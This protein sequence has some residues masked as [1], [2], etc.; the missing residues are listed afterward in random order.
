[1]R[2]FKPVFIATITDQAIENVRPDQDVLDLFQVLPIQLQAG[3]T[4]IVLAMVAQTQPVDGLRLL[5]LCVEV[6]VFY[7]TCPSPDSPSIK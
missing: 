3:Q 7:L 4:G 1:M 2:L 5:I 6:Q